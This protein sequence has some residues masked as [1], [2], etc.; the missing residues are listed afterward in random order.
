MRTNFGKKVFTAGVMLAASLCAW[1]VSGQ[2]AKPAADSGDKAKIAISHLFKSGDLIGLAVR[3]KAGES[4]GR[5]DD[6]V[7]DLRSGDVR[8]IALGYGGVAGIG[9]KIFAVPWDAMTFKMG[10]PNKADARF[11]VF[12]VTKESLDQKQGFDTS[13]WPNTADTAWAKTSA[14]SATKPA[15]TTSTDG[16]RPTVAYETVFRASKISGMDVRND[17]NEDLGDTSEVMIDVTKG[18]LKYL[19]L[20]HGTILTGGNKL[21]SVP[22]SQVTLAHANDRTYFKFNV[23]QQALKDAPSFDSSRWPG[24][25]DSNWW[26]GVDTYYE[27]TARRE[28]T[29]R[30]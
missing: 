7:V 2:E 14:A 16:Q 28:T 30:P 24:Y 19:V 11:F 17:A 13:H 21:F 12:D 6:L 25:S 23:S 4:I 5:V 3:N 22:L 10:E 27:R 9:A 15:T 1:S 8:Y 29:T 18:T 20:S 26:G